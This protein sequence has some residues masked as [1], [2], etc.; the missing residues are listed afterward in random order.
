MTAF[1]TVMER[2]KPGALTTYDYDLGLIEFAAADAAVAFRDT[3]M[4]AVDIS[5]GDV[6]RYQ[7]VVCR[8]PGWRDMVL[9]VLTDGCMFIPPD[10]LTPRGMSHHYAGGKMPAVHEWTVAFV[11]AFLAQMGEA[12][13][14]WV[15]S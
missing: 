14:A 4:A 12:L 13:A 3:G 15:Q 9:S 7:F 11:C 10:A 2:A 1:E 6:T 5:P 8:P